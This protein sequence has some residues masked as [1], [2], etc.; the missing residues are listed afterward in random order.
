MPRT[1]RQYSISNVYHIT[2]KG[3]D[4]Q[5]IFLDNHDKS[6][7]EKQ[8][9]E[10]KN[11]YKY[12]IY[13]YCL[14]NNHIHIVLKSEKEILSKAMQ[15]LG[16]RYTRYFNS[17]YERKGPLF[18]DRFFSKEIEN[19]TY[20]L[21]VCRYVHRN[22]ENAGIEKTEDY[23]W[24]SFKEYIGKSKIVNTSILLHY[25]DEKTIE[26]FIEYTTNSIESINAH[27]Y[28]E[29]DNYANLEFI[30]KLSDFE[31]SRLIMKK[32]NIEDISEFKDFFEKINKNEI[33]KI[34]KAIKN[35]NG[36]NKTQLHRITGINKRLLNKYWDE[37]VKKSPSPNDKCSKIPVPK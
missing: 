22:P 34:I 19:Q 9:L 37:S 6:F 3:I 18:Q 31:A 29:I 1:K 30:K 16:I 8:M 15:S 4:G 21:V 5:N 14:M 11:K 23:K 17:K 35:I 32:Y 33:E 13:A 2:L 28:S 26:R 20:F 24:S 7:F 27:N 25:L 10:T 12:E 36:I